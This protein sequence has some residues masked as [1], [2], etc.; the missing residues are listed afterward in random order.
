MATYAYFNSVPD[1]KK[2]LKYLFETTNT[3]DFK[4]KTFDSHEAIMDYLKD[5]NYGK[6]DDHPGVCFGWSLTENNRSSYDLKM[7]FNDHY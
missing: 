7:I 5:P 1:I 2:I 6:D 3:I 4:F